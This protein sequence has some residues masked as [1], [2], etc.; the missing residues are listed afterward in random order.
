M[1][2]GQPTACSTK[3]WNQRLE[4]VRLAPETNRDLSGAWLVRWD[5]VIEQ[6]GCAAICILV[7]SGGRP[8]S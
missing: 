1:R 4:S 8:E 2:G 6:C 7:Q 5:E 3:K